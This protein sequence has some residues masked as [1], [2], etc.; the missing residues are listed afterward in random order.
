MTIQAKLQK[1]IDAD[2]FLGE[3]GPMVRGLLAAEKALYAADPTRPDPDDERLGCRHSEV[4]SLAL[5]V[6]DEWLP[7][8]PHSGGSR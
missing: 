6:L 7:K 2:V 3:F 8:T 5:E 4:V 1:A